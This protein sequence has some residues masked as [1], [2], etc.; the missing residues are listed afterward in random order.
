MFETLIAS[1]TV[2]AGG[3]TNIDF[4]SIPQTY[5]DLVLVLSAR[6]NGNTPGLQ[7]NG[8]TTSKYNYRWLQG[9]GSGVSSATG[10]AAGGWDPALLIG[11]ASTT[12]DT[13]NVFASQQITIPNYAVTGAK[14]VSSDSV[15]E[16]NGSTAFQQII[17]G[18]W[19]G[20]AAITSIRINTGYGGSAFQQFTTAYLYGTL[21]GS[22]GATVS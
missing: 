13:S 3:A 21:R 7:F 12:S 20:T 16:N 9:N 5:T 14:V 17:S 15:S 11:P 22:G 6:V 2:G 19:V 18:Q 10:Y 8:D 1:V 4:T